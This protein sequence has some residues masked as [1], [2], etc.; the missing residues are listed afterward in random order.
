MKRILKISMLTICVMT[1]NSLST[2]IIDGENYT[3]IPEG[4]YE[5]KSIY[6]NSVIKSGTIVTIPNRSSGGWNSFSVRATLINNGTINITGIVG[7]FNVYKKV[8]NNGVITLTGGESYI[9][10]SGVF[11]N[12]G[13]INLPGWVACINNNSTFINKSSGIID[14]SKTSLFDTYWDKYF[15]GTVDCEAKSTVILP[16]PSFTGVKA[17]SNHTNNPFALNILITPQ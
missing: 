11:E 13:R 7:G 15:R 12:Y 2:E 17:N 9:R 3:I 8:I 5:Y 1:S 6:E 4:S 14:L 16:G 10:N